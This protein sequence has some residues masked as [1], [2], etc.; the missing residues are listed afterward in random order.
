MVSVFR[1]SSGPGRGF[2]SNWMIR[3]GSSF[4]IVTEVVLAFLCK[5]LCSLLTI[6]GYGRS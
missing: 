6:R 4:G 5:V 2:M 1:P 3:C